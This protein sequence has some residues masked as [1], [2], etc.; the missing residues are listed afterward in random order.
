MI[1]F[2][3]VCYAF[4]R[5]FVNEKMLYAIRSIFH[6]SQKGLLEKAYVHK[7]PFCLIFSLGGENVS[8]IN[9]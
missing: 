8:Q 7:K 5:R 2:L 4:V 1:I 3:I 9:F 6:F